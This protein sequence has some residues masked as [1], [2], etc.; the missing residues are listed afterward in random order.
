MFSLEPSL[1]VLRI[2]HYILIYS[3][4]EREGGRG[5]E[6]KREAI[7]NSLSLCLSC[8][9]MPFL[10][11]R[12][13]RDNML[14]NCAGKVLHYNLSILGLPI[15]WVNGNISPFLFPPSS[16]S[17]SSSPLPPLLFLLSSSLLLSSSAHVMEETKDAQKGVDF[18]RSTRENWQN[19]PYNFHLLWHLSLYYIGK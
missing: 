1:A 7:I 14:R 19:T 16:S 10:W 17:S 8:S 4:S 2:T 5:E 13:M 3:A 6:E 15:L 9:G 12:Q 11:R 18:M